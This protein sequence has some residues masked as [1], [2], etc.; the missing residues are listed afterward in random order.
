MGQCFLFLTI[1]RRRFLDFGGSI[2]IEG[3]LRRRGGA[4]EEKEQEKKCEVR[5]ATGDDMVRGSEFKARSQS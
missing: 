5:R 4:T 2:R 3:W 1:W